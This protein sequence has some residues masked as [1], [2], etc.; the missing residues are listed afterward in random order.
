MRADLDFIVER[1]EFSLRCE[2]SYAE[3]I[4]LVSGIIGSGKSTMALVMASLLKCEGSY[5]AKGVQRTILSMQF[6]E[7]HITSSSV[8]DEVRSW[9]LDP[10]DVL[11]HAGMEGRGELD[12]FKL[13]RGQLKRLNLACVFALD[14]DILLLDEPFSSLDCMVKTRICKAIESRR[15]KITMVFSH[16]RSVLPRVDSISHIA[17][18]RLVCHGATPDAV[19]EWSSPPP[20]LRKALENGARPRNITLQ[21]SM[22]ALCTIRD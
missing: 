14:P 3:G 7:Y 2:A 10:A 6:P 16:E 4:H 1:E 9:G 18:G 15:N 21:D 22:E 11:P 19:S 20:Y 12:P 5:S 13:S 8:D 17:E